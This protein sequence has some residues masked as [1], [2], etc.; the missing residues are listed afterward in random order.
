[1]I[2]FNGKGEYAASVGTVPGIRGCV[3]V[4]VAISRDG[5]R[6]YMLDTE[7]KIVRLAQPETAAK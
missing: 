5:K 2:Q 7:R 3:R 4:T 6:I 1:V